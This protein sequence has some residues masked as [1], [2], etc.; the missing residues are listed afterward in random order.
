M[1]TRQTAQSSIGRTIAIGTAAGVVGGLLVN[2]LRKGVVQ[3]PTALAGSWDQAL[4]AEHQAALAI[5]DL[6]EKTTD[7]QAARR[8]VLLVQLKHAVSKHAFQ[9]ENSIYTMMR[10]Q[11]LIE[12][13]DHLNHEHGYVKQFFFDLGELSRSDPAWLSKLRE[14]RRQIET[15]M[16]EEEDDLFPRMREQLSAEQNK[17]LTLLMN[18]EGLKLA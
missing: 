3:A 18:R 1:A 2:A 14:F 8:T 12:A 4:A 5:F 9:E 10:D 6:L 11:G 13:A 7:D 17:H 16:R 15:H